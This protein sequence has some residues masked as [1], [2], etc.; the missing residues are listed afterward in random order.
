MNVTPLACPLL[1]FTEIA[2]TLARARVIE[3]AHLIRHRVVL[4]DT[5]ADVG[6]SESHL[7]GLEVRRCAK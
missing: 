3:D 2:W 1:G 6:R 7:R 5:G 4:N